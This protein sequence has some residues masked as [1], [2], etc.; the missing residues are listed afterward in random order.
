MNTRDT[1]AQREDFYKRIEPLDVAPLWERLKGLVPREPTPAGVS[2]QWRYAQLRPYLMEA[3]EHISAEEAE[4]RVLLLE[5]PGL[6]G[7][8]QITNTLFSG[9]QL[10][11]P[12]EL[13][14]KHRHTQSALRFIVEG[15]GAYT[16]VDDQQVVM[17]PGDFV[18]TPSW[19]WHHHGNETPGPM[20][21][22]DGLDI[23]LVRH[24]NG[25]FREDEHEWKKP[26]APFGGLVHF[27]YSRAR[28]VLDAMA[29]NGKPDQHLG[30]LMRYEDPVDGGWAMPTIA[31]MIRLVPPGFTT[32]PYRSSDG[33]V[34]VGV[35]GRGRI[36]VD[37]S[38][39][40]V[41]PH[42]VVVVPGWMKY[43]LA[44]EGDWVLFSF[45]DRAAQE[46]LGFF[47]EQR[48]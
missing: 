4:R 19:R 33:M 28:G 6:R 43:T 15:D 23:P 35:K 2:H 45:S 46:R 5:N 17:R 11:M 3:A 48:L 29:R 9:L 34:F 1:K 18:V 27:P 20:V 7:G 10:I 44:A 36:D 21:W 26:T 37:G 38:T 40:D 32:R 14:P 24:F 47:R 25:T 39:Y 13:A 16:T 41:D 42:D 22:L 8:S 31:P 12:G 30:Y